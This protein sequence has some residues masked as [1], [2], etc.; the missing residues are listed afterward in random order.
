M[1]DA[2]LSGEIYVN[3]FVRWMYVV[4]RFLFT[5]V[6]AVTSCIVHVFLTML[7]GL[8]H[9]LTFMLF[10]M[11][12]YQELEDYVV[13]LCLMLHYLAKYM[14]IVLLDGCMWSYAFSINI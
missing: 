9:I 7:T 4:I 5:L 14:S 13:Y 6:S 11:L 3:C 1:S 10:A 8:T 12:S 2:A